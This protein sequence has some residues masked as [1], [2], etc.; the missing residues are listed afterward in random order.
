MRMILVRHTETKWNEERRYIGRTD[1]DLSQL[2]EENAQLMADYFRHEEIKSIYSSALQRAKQTAHAI[3]AYHDLSVIEMPGLNEV[4]FGEW[5]GM[6]HEEI[7]ENYGSLI[8]NWLLDPMAVMVPG[9]E[10]WCEFEARV[11]KS[12]HKIITNETKGKIVV[13]S[14]GGPIKVIIGGTLKIPASGY[15]Q[16]YQDKGAINAINYEGGRN[17]LMLL[18]D[19]CYRRMKNGKMK[20]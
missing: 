9:G 2:G 14:H 17:Q 16:I 20:L 11:H 5:E 19:T 1:L 10:R 6:T 7:G 12:V 13:V 4:D 3:A 15:W 8:Y 18:N